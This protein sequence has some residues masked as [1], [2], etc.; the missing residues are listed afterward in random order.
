MCRKYFRRLPRQHARRL[1]QDTVQLESACKN[2]LLSD[3]RRN[4][5]EQSFLSSQGLEDMIPIPNPIQASFLLRNHKRRVLRKP[6][7]NFCL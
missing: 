3:S 6:R 1:L 5:S 2:L 7:S 4:R